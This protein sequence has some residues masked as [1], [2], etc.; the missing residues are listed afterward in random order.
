MTSQRIGEFWKLAGKLVRLAEIGAA[1]AS[2]IKTHL[3]NT[4]AQFGHQ[5]GGIELFDHLTNVIVPLNTRVQGVAG[6]LDRVPAVCKASM[7]A[8]LRAIASELFQPASASL[9]ALLT[10]LAARM[11]PASGSIAPSGK[12][13]SYFQA[14]YGFTGFPTSGSPT[15]AD[16]LITTTVV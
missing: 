12:F 9:P 13:Y 14:N 6:S 2:G 1:D 3:V 15:Y 7:D 16:S 10:A 5:T 4:V 8:Y 11:A